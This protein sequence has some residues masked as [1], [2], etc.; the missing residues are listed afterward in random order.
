MSVSIRQLAKFTGVKEGAL[1]QMLQS[2][3][4]EV[5]SESS[6]IDNIS[7]EHVV[8]E[9]KHQNGPN[10]TTKESS[11]SNRK[12]HSKIRSK[13]KLAYWIYISHGLTVA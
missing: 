9:F 3:G 2:I 13:R 1:I 8:D 7:A 10:K 6:T 4:Y 5:E 12:V 11:L